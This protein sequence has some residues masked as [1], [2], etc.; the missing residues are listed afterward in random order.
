MDV[1][2]M[3]NPNGAETTKTMLQDATIKHGIYVLGEPQLLR[4]SRLTM[5]DEKFNR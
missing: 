3:D 1:D 4:Y 5:V 2:K